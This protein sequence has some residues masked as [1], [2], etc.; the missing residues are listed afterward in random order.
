MLSRY[1]A[2]AGERHYQL[3]VSTQRIRRLEKTHD[4]DACIR[5]LL[6][7]LLLTS[8]RLRDAHTALL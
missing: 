6:S 4:E 2:E 3:F 8:F 1:K 5:P 7:L